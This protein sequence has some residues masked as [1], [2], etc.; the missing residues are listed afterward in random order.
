MTSTVLKPRA[1]QALEPVK[2]VVA[3]GNK[4]RSVI[5]VGIDEAGR[6]PVVG[7]MFVAAVALDSEAIEKLR[8]IGLKD[9]KKL[10]P[11]RRNALKKMIEELALAYTII[12][13]PPDVLD[14]TNV[15]QATIDAMKEA[16]ERILEKVKPDVVIA[17]IVGSGKGQMEKLKEVFPIVVIEPK[18]DATHL[19]VSA[20][21]VLAKEAREEHIK[22]LKLKYGDFG[23]GYPSDKRT[24]EWLKENY[25]KEVVRKRWKSVQRV[26]RMQSKS[27]DRGQDL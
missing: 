23:S 19:A 18:A 3:Q 2:T 7:S 14:R 26:L 27:S 22:R 1:R 25:D 13:V 5:F 12:E 24:I 9:S 21:S 8:R 20:A 17:D 10:T 6:G 16:L 11:K 15:S 4:G